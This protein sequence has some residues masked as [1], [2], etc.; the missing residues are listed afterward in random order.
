MNIY[1]KI[2]EKWIDLIINNMKLIIYNIISLI[3][4]LILFQKKILLKKSVYFLIKIMF[5]KI[6]LEQIFAKLIHK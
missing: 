1:L 4:Y 5:C 6:D 2:S 3:F